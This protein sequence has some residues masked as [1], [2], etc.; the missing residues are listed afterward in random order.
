MGDITKFGALNTKLKVLQGRLLKNDDY[1]SLLKAE[2]LEEAV[3]Y[4]LSNTYYGE[5]LE[6]FAFNGRN[7]EDLEVLMKN[8]YFENLERFSHFMTDFYKKFFNIVLMR[9]EVENIK[10]MLRALVKG[11]SMDTARDHMLMHGTS[12]LEYDL[13]LQSR[14]VGE[15]I[16]GLKGTNYHRVISSYVNEPVEKMLF[17]ME[18]SLDRLYFDILR[19]STKR[20]ANQEVQNVGALVGTNIDLLNIQWIYRG[21][22]FYGLSSEE[23]INYTL[24]GGKNLDFD[25]LKKLCYATSPEETEA[26][27]K[28]TVYGSIFKDV[29]N[30]DIYME[31]SIQRYLD[32]MFSNHKTKNVM[33]VAETMVYMH[34]MEY[35]IRDL[36]SIFELKRYG[37]SWEEGKSFLVRIL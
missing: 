11:E 30:F 7:L 29:D 24:N 27:I 36:F 3:E 6:G 28:E 31:R 2:T 16:E 1:N 26:L 33:N 5:F 37:M 34:K 35:E 10:F 4:L 21:R 12:K 22:K 25:E 9:Y 15:F 20:L 32:K 19:K 13:L 18:M 8:K 17:Y 14:N 23:L